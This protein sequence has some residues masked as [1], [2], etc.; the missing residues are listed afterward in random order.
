MSQPEAKRILLIGAGRLGIR[1]LEALLRQPGAHSY[2]IAGRDAP[3]TIGLANLARQYASS[4]GDMVNIEPATIDVSDIDATAATIARLQPD[5]IFSAVTM[6]SWWVT[7]TLPAHLAAPLTPA[8]VGPWLPMHLTLI[9]ELMQ[10][11]RAAS[12]PAT[13]VNASYPDVTHPVLAAADLA[14]HIGIGNIAIPL[15]GLRL[16]VAETHH[17]PL[18]DV[19]LRAVFHHYVNYMATRTG[20]P[21][22]APMHI[23]GWLGGDPAHASANSTPLV[24]DTTRVF[25][26]LTSTLKRLSGPD[27]QHV[28]GATAA[29][30]LRALLNDTDVRT[31]APGPLGLPGG[32]PVHLS[33]G[34]IHLDLPAG[35]DLAKAVRI[36][37][38]GGLYDGIESIDPTGTVRTRAENLEPLTRLLGYAC[39][40]LR[41]VDSRSRAEE[42]AHR[43][44][45]YAAP[46][47]PSFA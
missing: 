45:Q 13:V 7:G 33:A 9:Y 1:T 47:L 34:Q 36:N 2:V 41:L 19:H 18:S 25:E 42:L 44:A 8:C 22:P 39:R 21:R 14:P 11:I 10:A 3:R 30:V 32:Y 35:V 46:Q 29:I 6:Q 27:F 4:F 15:V 16:H 38:D 24:F 23:S 17:V 43:F 5:V 26:P 28:T 40:D 31:H 20:D 12:S 37:T